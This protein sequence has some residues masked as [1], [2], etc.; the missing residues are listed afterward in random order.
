MQKGGQGRE[1]LAN[2]GIT[3]AALFWSRMIVTA[4]SPWVT[5]ASIIVGVIP[6]GLSAT[7]VV[8]YSIAVITSSMCGFDAGNF[9]VYS[10]ILRIWV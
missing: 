7:A 4:S 8:A 3:T 5:V 9:M 1:V 10:P 6:T 2:A